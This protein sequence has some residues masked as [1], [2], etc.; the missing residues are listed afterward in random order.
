MATEPHRSVRA[1]LR[2]HCEQ[3]QRLSPLLA[4]RQ[5]AQGGPLERE[6]YVPRTLK[7]RHLPP[8]PVL[9]GGRTKTHGCVSF[10]GTPNKNIG[11]LLVAY[12]CLGGGNHLLLGSEGQP[13]LFDVPFLLIFILVLC[14]LFWEENHLLWFSCKLAKPL[15]RF[16]LC[17]GAYGFP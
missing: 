15:D 9:Y 6:K 4:P 2:Q 8:P 1:S 12:F 13:T 5:G 14:L 10:L 17:E 7:T 16:H 11:F 3:L